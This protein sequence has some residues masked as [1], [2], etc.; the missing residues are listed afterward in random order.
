LFD[1]DF[2]ATTRTI[3]LSA[4]SKTAIGFAM[5]SS[6]RGRQTIGVT[7][8][9][10]VDF[11]RALGFY[12]EVKSYDEIEELAPEGDA[13]VVDMAGNKNVL[14]RV[15][16][17]LGA[18]L[19]YSM[20]IGMSHGSAGTLG[21]ERVPDGE[22]PGPR[23]ELFFA[24][25]QVQKRLEDWGPEVYGQRVARDLA[26]FIEGSTSWLELEHSRGGEELEATYRALLAGRLS[27]RRGQIASLGA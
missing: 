2:F 13:V 16:R 22:P 23:Q 20:G 3:V 8:P 21:A 25:T 12:D 4:S 11:V 9:R 14:A 15:H 1:Q 6:A 10:N 27:P 7:S 18:A 5:Q 26:R 24:P 17:L 19:R